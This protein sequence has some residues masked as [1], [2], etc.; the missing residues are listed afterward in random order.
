MATAARS[1][2][3]LTQSKPLRLLT[4]LLFG[5]VAIALHEGINRRLTGLRD[6]VRAL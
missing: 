1:G 4:L 6:A 5:L 2:L 3:I